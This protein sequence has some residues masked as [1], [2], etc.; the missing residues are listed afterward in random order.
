MAVCARALRRDKRVLWSGQSKPQKMGNMLISCYKYLEVLNC[1]VK[2]PAELNDHS[3]A[4][5]RE[6]CALYVLEPEQQNARVS[7]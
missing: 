5:F 2:W 6:S 3:A 1:T 7:L 4:F